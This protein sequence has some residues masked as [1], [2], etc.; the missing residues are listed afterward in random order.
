MAPEEDVALPTV[1]L[2]NTNI[3]ARPT[4]N[5]SQLSPQEMDDSVPVLEEKIRKFKPEVVII[6]GK[7]IWE[8]IWRVRHGRKMKKEDFHYGWQSDSENMGISAN[9]KTEV[10]AVTTASETE[11]VAKDDSK[12]KITPAEAIATT[13]S[14]SEDDDRSWSGAKV[15]V[16]TSTSGL[17]AT[18][19][20]AEK[21][22]IWRELGSW[23][24]K[25]RVERSGVKT[26]ISEVTQHGLVKV[27]ERGQV[28]T[29]KVEEKA[30]QGTVKL[31]EA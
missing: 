7:S 10:T 25:R 11:V 24:E 18:P 13:S 21:Q 17:A 2:G 3:V 12:V 22:I 8:S 16:A 1:G 5:G 19:S 27:E 15:F 6:V 30:Q 28:E 9:I 14:K 26:Q 29:I 31:E 20:M 23:I 4:Q